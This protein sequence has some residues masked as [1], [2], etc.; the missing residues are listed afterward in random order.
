[1]RRL[2]ITL[3]ALA[4]SSAALARSPDEGKYISVGETDGVK[5]SVDSLGLWGPKGGKERGIS[6]LWVKWEPLTPE[7]WKVLANVGG[8]K[9]PDKTRGL[10]AMYFRIQVDCTLKRYSVHGSIAHDRH[11]QLLYV[12]H[13]D[14][15]K[16]TP[17]S[18]NPQSAIAQSVTHGCAAP[19]ATFPGKDSDFR[20]LTRAGTMT[21]PD[22]SSVQPP[23]V[24]RTP[25]PTRTRCI[26]PATGMQMMDPNGSCVG[27]DVGGSRYGQND[28]SP[29][30][31]PG[32]PGFDPHAK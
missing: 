9:P 11:G 23:P 6:I 12:Q 14:R 4:I 13:E 18:S 7:G 20:G 17:L 1:M 8:P 21:R 32:V 10:A 22:P 28:R 2:S 5:M 15:L 16:W 26:N 19:Y 25:E 24:S 27:N 3:A 31:L 29:M 30:V